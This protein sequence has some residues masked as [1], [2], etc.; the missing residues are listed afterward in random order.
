MSTT[1]TKINT[2]KDSY[3]QVVCWCGN[4]DLEPYSED[5]VKC[6]QCFTLVSKRRPAT[7][8]AYITDDD[9]DLYGK[10]YWG[11]HQVEMGHPAIAER[12]YSELPE[13]CAYWLRNIVSFVP[14]P[15]KTLELGC[16]HGGLV[17]L[18]RLAGYDAAGLELSP[19]ITNF[20]R[21]EFKIPVFEGPA[22]T[23]GFSNGEF[24]VL[25]MM[26]VIEHLYT[27]LKTMNEYT[28]FLADDAVIVIQTPQ[29]DPTK[30][31]ETLLE[32]DDRFLSL[33]EAD[34]H[35]YLF[36]AVSLQLLLAKI[37]FTYYQPVEAIF[38][39]Y[40]QFVFASRKS[41]TPPNLEN[42]STTLNKIEHSAAITLKISDA[43]ET[44]STFLQRACDERLRIINDFEQQLQQKINDV[45]ALREDN[46]TLHQ[47]LD[48]AAKEYENKAN[49]ISALQNDNMMLH[50]HLDKAA[51][52]SDN[53]AKQIDALQNDKLV[54]QQRLAE[55]AKECEDRLTT[56]TSLQNQY[57]ALETAFATNQQL[58]SEQNDLLAELQ[59]ANKHLI[60][61]ATIANDSVALESSLSQ[62]LANLH[63]QAL[64]H[65]QQKDNLLQAQ[66]TAINGLSEKIS[67]ITAELNTV[68]RQHTHALYLLNSI[69]ATTRLN[70]TQKEHLNRYLT[71]IATASK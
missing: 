11:E 57:S 18:M 43:G 22:E 35:L 61:T 33:L 16:S 12:A 6:G 25:L 28:K 4:S 58:L 5:Y 37:G 23:H 71:A 60:S 54:L 53:Q 45:E 50:Q 39:H 8:P 15:A 7:D 51:K 47:R 69:N 36:S 48:E 21:K 9:N 26:D 66:A 30:S 46:Q 52:E 24:D 20:A 38:S 68:L 29:Y 31:Y 17:Y 55:T 41:M 14:P 65:L 44:R 19:S 42:L 1:S 59:L 3:Q 67:A 34:E 63:T 64:N 49:Q 13:R 10:N 40:D 32:T 70:R 2:N 62:H 27:P 56:I